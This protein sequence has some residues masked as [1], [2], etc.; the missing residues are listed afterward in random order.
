MLDSLSLWEKRNAPI[1]S[2]SGG[3]KRRVLIAKALAHEP[4]ILFLD[5][6]TAGVD[7]ELRQDMWSVVESLREVDPEAADIVFRC[8]RPITQMG[9]D[10]TH[11][12]LSTQDRVERIRA[13]DNPV[14]TAV[15][16][17]LGFFERFDM[18]KYAS[19][20][21]PLHD[22]CTVAYLLRP[23][24][25]EGKVCNVAVETRSELTLGHTAVDF[26]HV[27]DRPR[28]VRWIHSVDAGGFY[29]L[30]VER[31]DAAEL[32]HV[33][34]LVVRRGGFRLEIPRWT[35]AAGG[36][37]GVVGPNGAGKTTLLESVAGLRRTHGGEDFHLAGRSL[38]SWAAGVSSTASA[39]SLRRWASIARKPAAVSTQIGDS[40]ACPGSFM[41]GLY[42]GSGKRAN[43][44]KMRE[45]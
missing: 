8:G 28:N 23:E 15:A 13:L 30:L 24:L 41:V 26:W 1:M 3:M 43:Q 17:M 40:G 16:G 44:E 4:R 21:A 7:V 42:T 20:G 45:T 2:L 37:V 36:V 25:F 5:E 10:V 22:P 33:E 29:D 27:T 31:R 11:Q 12:V 35:V 9:L 39:G 19:K 18:E 6:P 32:I 14:A 38:G 34:G